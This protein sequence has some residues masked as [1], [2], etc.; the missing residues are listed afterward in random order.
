M[1]VPK[2]GI[3]FICVTIPLLFATAAHATVYTVPGVRASIAIALADTSIHVGDVVL[4]SAN[5]K[6]TG[7]HALVM[8][9]GIQVIATTNDTIDIADSYAVTFPN[10]SPS[11]NTVLSGFRITGYS[12]A[13][14]KIQVGGSGA[15]ECRIENCAFPPSG[16]TWV[17][18]ANSSAGGN[19][20]ITGNEM[21]S[22][23]NGLYLAG[24]PSSWVA[25]H[26]YIHD[27]GTGV[28]LEGGSPVVEHNTLADNTY[29]AAKGASNFI[30]D[31]AIQPHRGQY[32]WGRVPWVIFGERSWQ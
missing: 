22:S 11:A 9:A 3:V 10:S 27:C 30:R 4:V 29:G 28:L 20:R 2:K 26:N 25:D 32:D 18:E 16:G 6:E 7:T 8:R 15:A 24:A 14:V 17:I 5:Y 23:T 13:A 21:Y 12:V 31:F 1:T 19:V